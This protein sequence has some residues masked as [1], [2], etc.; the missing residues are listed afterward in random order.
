[1]P[2]GEKATPKGKL[3]TGIFLVS[4]GTSNAYACENIPDII[5]KEIKNAMKIPN[6]LN[7]LP[8]KSTKF[9]NFDIMHPF[10]K[11]LNYFTF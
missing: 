7:L 11:C 5:K 8:L 10:I 6:P 4:L 9:F 2:L 3:P 1:L